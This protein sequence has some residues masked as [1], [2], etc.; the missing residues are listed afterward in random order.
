[1]QR[2]SA[3]SGTD[4]GSAARTAPVTDL[5]RLRMLSL[6]ADQVGEGVA[7]VDNDAWCLYANPAFAT[8]HACPTDMLE[9]TRFSVFYSP[10]EW[11]GPVQS[12]MSDALST[13][14]GRAEVTRCRLDGTT[15]E[16]HVTLS[17]LRDAAG[18]LI[19]RILCVQDITA[20][21]QLEAQLHRAAFHD[22]LTDLPNRR[23]L[24]DRLDHA[25]AVAERAHTAVAVLF[26][27]LDGFKVVNDTHG[28]DA[29]DQLLVRT[30]DR[31]RWCL[32]AAD[33]LARLGGDEF[34]VLLEGV[35]DSGQAA[36]NARRIL[37]ALAQPFKL[38]RAT[39]RISASVGIAVAGAG[40]PRS[41]LHAADSA[42]Y[43]AK[44]TGPGQMVVAGCD[45]VSGGT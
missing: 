34:V 43:Q 14:V 10:A 41:L 9:K 5:N 16:A 44:T 37:R 2:G 42:M 38:D 4:Y 35:T 20:R 27:D 22:P 32:R 21:K 28:D 19:G 8:M 13:G 6:V 36:T 25:L 1:M 26:I 29:G 45:L 40:S 17:L 18:T 31:L 7:V 15:F 23:L 24:L 12:L 11:N 30:A 3:V 33:S 39:V